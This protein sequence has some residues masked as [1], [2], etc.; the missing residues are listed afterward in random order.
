MDII[1]TLCYFILTSDEDDGHVLKA[2]SF[3]VIFVLSATKLK[4]KNPGKTS[5]DISPISS[6]NFLGYNINFYNFKTFMKIM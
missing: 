2:P 3:C 1:V 5:A 6:F 4:K